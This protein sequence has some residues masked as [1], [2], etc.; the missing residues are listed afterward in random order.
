MLVGCVVLPDRICSDRK[1]QDYDRPNRPIPR[2]GNVETDLIRSK[3]KRG[4]LIDIA[5]MIFAGSMHKYAVRDTLSSSAGVQGILELVCITVAFLLVL[6]ATWGRQ[7]QFSASLASVCFFVSGL[8]AL[9]SSWRSFYPALS[10]VKGMLLMVVLATGYLASQDGWGQRYVR[11]V[12]RGYTLLLGLGLIAG[13]LLP[14]TYPLFSVDP[15]SGRT[16]MSIFDTFFGVVGED[17]ALMLLAASVVSNRPSWTARGFLL[18]VNILAGGK[19]STILL[20]SLL[21][22]RVLSDMRTRRSLGLVFFALG[23]ACIG[24]LVAALLN[25]GFLLHFLAHSASSIYGDQVGT[26]ATG[27]DGRLGLWKGSLSILPSAWLLGYG[28]GGARDLLLKI[29]S[30]SGNSHNGY[31]EMALSGGI[32]GFIVFAVGICAVIRVCSQAP[33]PVRVRFITLLVFILVDAL[34]GDIFGN[35]SFVGVLFLLWMPYEVEAVQRAVEMRA[36]AAA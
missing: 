24:V 21:C 20:L 27:L 36:P 11:A 26:E 4:W 35:P 22:I 28:F 29:A 18:I 30:W 5:G 25:P 19:A 9:A 32:S 33:L 2:I 7:R 14:R 1:S 34:V 17:A 23:T 6:W 10:I 15:Y 3:N 8:F 16:T 31:L 13:V 12:Y